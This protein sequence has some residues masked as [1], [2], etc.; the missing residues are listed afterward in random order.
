MQADHR[1][2]IVDAGSAYV[3]FVALSTLTAVPLSTGTP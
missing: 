1:R 3:A 2:V